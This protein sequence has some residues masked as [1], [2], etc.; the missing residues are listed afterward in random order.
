MP[1]ETTQLASDLVNAYDRL[2]VELVEPP[3]TPAAILLRWPQKP[4]ITTPT[5][6]ATWQQRQYKS[7]RRGRRIGCDQ[8]MTET[9]NDGGGMTRMPDLTG[10]LAGAPT[11]LDR[12]D[13]DP[14]PLLTVQD[15]V[16]AEVQESAEYRGITRDQRGVFCLN[17]REATAAVDSVQ[18]LQEIS[19][20]SR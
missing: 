19:A 20:L 13:S 15:G 2:T 17:N 3:D 1:N 14:G 8:G 12:F 18:K 11:E 5:P 10:L 16:D 7:W 4:S 9:V 6:S